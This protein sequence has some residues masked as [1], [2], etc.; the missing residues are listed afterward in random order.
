MYF[1]EKIKLR[2]YKESDIEDSYALI[3]NFEVRSMLG[4]SIIFP[5]SLDEQKEF[6]KIT[7][8]KTLL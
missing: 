6:V 7:R 4:G 1:G 3:E 5:F 2:A 8:K